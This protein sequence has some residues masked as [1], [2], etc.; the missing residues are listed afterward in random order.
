MFLFLTFKIEEI[1]AEMKPDNE[2]EVEYEVFVKRV[3]SS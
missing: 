1:I 2:N 3:F